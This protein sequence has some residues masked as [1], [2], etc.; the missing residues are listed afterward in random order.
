M[1]RPAIAD[2][3]DSIFEI[4]RA[5]SV[6]I[7]RELASRLADAITSGKLPPGARLENETSLSERLGISRPTIRRVI[8]ELVGMGLLVRRQGIGTVVVPPALSRKMELVSLWDDLLKMG[9]NPSTKLLKREIIPA[10]AH[11]AAELGITLGEDVLHLR[12]LRLANGVPLV[13]MENFLPGQYADISAEDLTSRGLY[14][15][16]GRRGVTIQVAH[17]S[18]TARL[19]TSAESDLLDLPSH[20]ALLTSKRTAYDALGKASETGNHCYRP[21]LYAFEFTLVRG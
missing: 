8:E 7:Y 19:A 2:L 18:V 20:A 17:Q 16:L 1:H 12:R 11:V 10:D 9:Q 5:S 21:D 13:I 6:P 14:Q 3:P 4:D 15:N